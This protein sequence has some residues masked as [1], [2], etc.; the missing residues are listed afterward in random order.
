MA[1]IRNHI[2]QKHWIR[3][4]TH[5]VN[6]PVNTLRP[7]QNGGNFSDD[8]FNCIFLNENVLIS[9]QISLKFVPKG[10]IKNMPALVSI[11]AWRRI[12]N[13]PLSEPIVVSL[14][15]HI[16]A[17]R[18]QWVNRCKYKKPQILRSDVNGNRYLT[19]CFITRKRQVGSHIN[20]AYF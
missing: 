13:K 1:W 17:T 2:P 12:G 7:R 16:C 8:I 3:L 11:M 18:P 5:A 10:P 15:T 6:I 19:H 20:I 9:I 4:L 14:L